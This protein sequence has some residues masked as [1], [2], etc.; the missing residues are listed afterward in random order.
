MG[1]RGP[2]ET[3]D[4]AGPVGPLATSGFTFY[5]GKGVS[6]TELAVRPDMGP[7]AL[8]PLAILDI[9]SNYEVLKNCT[10][11]LQ[12]SVGRFRPT[13]VSPALIIPA[14]TFFFEGN[15]APDGRDNVFT[16]FDTTR[17]VAFSG[18]QKNVAK[19]APPPPVFLPASLPRAASENT[20]ASR[21]MTMAIAAHS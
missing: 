12:A 18:D 17:V 16:L 14:T 21:A 15:V 19:F 1:A 10:N 5:D 8:G 20:K 4:P 3:V 7:G 9:W 11:L 6:F 2:G 13:A